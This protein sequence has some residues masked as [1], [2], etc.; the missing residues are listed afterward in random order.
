MR[1]TVGLSI[2]LASAGIGEAVKVNPLPAPTSITWGTSGSIPVSGTFKLNGSPNSIIVAAWNRAFGTITSLQWV[3]Q[4]T[5]AP[6]ATYAPFPTTVA[7]VR[8]NSSPTILNTVDLHVGNGF[9]D[10]QH[11]VDESYTIDIV[12]TS[13]II[14]VTAPTTWGILHAFTTLQQLII[15]DGNGGLLIEQPVSIKD[16]PLYPYRGIMIDSGRNF[17][18]VAKIYEQIDGMALSKL[19][20][21]HWHLDDSQ[22]WPVQLSSYPS[23]TLDAYSASEQYSKTDLQNVIAYASARGVRVIPEV[24]MPGHASS[25]WKQVDPSIVACADSW[26]SNDNWPYHTAVEPNPGQLEILNSKTYTVVGNVYNELSEIFTDNFFH[27][28]GDELQEGCYNFSS[29]TQQWFAANSSRGYN[30]L[31]QYW[32]DNALPI[33]TKPKNRQLIMWEDM[34][35]GSPHANTVPTNIIMQTWNNGLGNIQQLTAAGY[36]VIV[37]SSDFFYLDCGFGGWVSN[38]PRYDVRESLSL[39]LVT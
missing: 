8:R 6:I 26:W 29:I 2:L 39:L 31:L 17:I 20:V 25:G 5:E 10:L 19:N 33:F 9:V 21:L 16:A 28:G 12:A 34:A 7:K 38:D 35:I 22:S 4:A 14:T 3:P 13:N 30:D 27:V 24:D 1:I 15:S 11:G 37:S 36:D 18:S 32:V 23:M